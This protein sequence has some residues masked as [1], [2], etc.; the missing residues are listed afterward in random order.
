ML[1]KSDVFFGLF[2]L[3][4]NGEFEKSD[5]RTTKDTHEESK[6]II[7]R[8]NLIYYIPIRHFGAL[9]FGDNEEPIF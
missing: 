7:D 5:D 2:L 9:D 8:M 4:E 3:F 6:Y 1:S